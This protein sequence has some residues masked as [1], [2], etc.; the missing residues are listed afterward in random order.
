MSC[1]LTQGSGELRTAGAAGAWAPPAAT[2]VQG[3]WGNVLGPLELQHRRAL[4]PKEEITQ[5]VPLSLVMPG[6]VLS[7]KHKER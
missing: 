1:A 3:C 2:G 7:C 6:D 5:R 4:F